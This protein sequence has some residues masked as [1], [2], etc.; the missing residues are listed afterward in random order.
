M[1]NHDSISGAEIVLMI[2]ALDSFIGSPE[3]AMHARSREDRDRLL[4]Y[5]QLRRRFKDA[6]H[7]SFYSRA[8]GWLE[9]ELSRE[10]IALSDKLHSRLAE[11][12]RDP[13]ANRRGVREGF[14]AAF[15][16]LREVRQSTPRPLS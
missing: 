2:E 5:S 11:L 12:L 13:Q 10:R 7:M 1:G 9:D 6:V 3:D 8:H 16:E 14:V 4:P 15:R